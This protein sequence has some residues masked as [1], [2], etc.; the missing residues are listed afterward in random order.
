LQRDPSIKEVASFTDAI[1]DQRKVFFRKQYFF[2]DY[3][4]ERKQELGRM[5][6]L[7]SESIIS[8]NEYLVVVDEINENLTDR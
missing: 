5:K 7:F 1:Y 3:D 2:I 4:G 8:E 6:W